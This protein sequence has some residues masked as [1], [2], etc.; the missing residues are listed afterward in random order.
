MIAPSDL[1]ELLLRGA[2]LGLFVALAVGLLRDPRAPSRLTGALFCLGAAG[3]TITQSAVITHSLG[4]A[5]APAWVLSVVAGGLFWA[6]AVELFGDHRVVRPQLFLPVVA[7]LAVSV[8]A[9]A[10]PPAWARYLW[11]LQNLINAALMIHVLAVTWA[12][13][14]DDLVESRRRLRGPMLA[15]AAI[16][17]LVISGVQSTELFSRPASQLSLLAAIVLLALGLAGS[18]V[19]LLPDERL[20]GR[21]LRPAQA[22]APASVPVQDR[23]TLE[24][25]R[26]ALDDEEVWRRE[27]LTIGALAQALG[28]PEHRL[29]KIINEG[30]GYRNFAA[31]L[32]ERRVAAAK[33]ALADPENARKPVSSIAFDVGFNSL[34]SFNRVFREL[35]GV[36]PTVFRQRALGGAIPEKPPQN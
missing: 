5:I 10:A 12:G 35:A 20:F 8:A 30:L 31:F 34:A 2:A 3:H 17:A 23:A 32:G 27:D 36:A 11:L 14:R 1:A 22:A 26:K 4:A 16:Y 19:F 15:A 29:R 9:L 24:R 6:F 28:V 18:L 25:L 7:L 33:T 21:R 13:L